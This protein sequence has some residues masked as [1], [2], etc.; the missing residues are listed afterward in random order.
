MSNP[1]VLIVSTKADVATDDVVRQLAKRGIAHIRVNTEDY[2]FSDVY[3]WKPGASGPAFTIGHQRIPPPTAIWY[4]RVR[5]P[6]KPEAMDDG[7]YE[8]CLQENRA[9]LLGGILGL[10]A[11]WMSNPAA[12][13]RSEFKPFQLSVASRIGLQIPPTLISNDPAAIREAR[14]TFGE[15][16]VKPAR[17]GYVV[18]DGQ[19]F[20]I[21]TSRLREEDLEELESARLSPAIY[22]ALVPKLC[23]VRVTIVGKKV[24]AAAIDSQSDPAAMTDWRHTTN[25]ELPHRRIDLPHVLADQLLLM[26][27]VLGLTFAAIDLIHS[28]DG[29]FVFLEVN[30]SG[31]WLWLDDKLE[32]GISAAVAN[33]LAGIDG[34]RR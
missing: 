3:S 24:F 4:R 10:D 17:T 22:Q 18:H 31:Q 6:S 13:W 27:D 11:R 12:I 25:P 20:S 2:P 29:S 16:I 32:L 30:P 28:T 26:M 34:A 15:M 7:I 1:C 9:A 8:F 23:D 33:W 14:D 21:F 5:S 19:A